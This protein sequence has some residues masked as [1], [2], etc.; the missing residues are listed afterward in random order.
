MAK[1]VPFDVGDTVVPLQ[2]GGAAPAQESVTEELANPK[3]A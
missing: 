2:V 1:L 3:R